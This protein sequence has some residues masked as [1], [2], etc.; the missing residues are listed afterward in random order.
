MRRDLVARL[1][2]LDLDLAGVEHDVRVGQDAFALDDDAGAGHFR[3]A[4]LVHG[5]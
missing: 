2:G 4:C 1:V 3:G 5:S